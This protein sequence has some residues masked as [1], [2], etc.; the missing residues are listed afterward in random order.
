MHV[1]SRHT[2][3]IGENGELVCMFGICSTCILI[4]IYIKKRHPNRISFIITKINWCDEKKNWICSFWCKIM[5]FFSILNHFILWSNQIKWKNDEMNT[6]KKNTKT[7]TEPIRK[8]S[9]ISTLCA[10]ECCFQFIISTFG[11]HVPFTLNRISN[12]PISSCLLEWSQSR[13]PYGIW[14][15]FSVLPVQNWLPLAGALFFCFDRHTSMLVYVV[16][17][18]IYCM[19]WNGKTS[20][21]QTHTSYQFK[22]PKISP[23]EVEFEC[24]VWT[25]DEKYIYI[26]YILI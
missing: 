11:L 10:A 24:F 12:F 16:C 13:G 4:S 17:N 2:C 15:S 5:F 22:S 26:L 18:K 21:F 9:D 1:N 19:Q 14:S 6:T 25:I 23:I 8:C 7:K 3:Q 20:N